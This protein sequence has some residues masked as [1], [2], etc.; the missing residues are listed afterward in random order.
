MAIFLSILFLVSIRSLLLNELPL[1]IAPRVNGVPVSY[2]RTE[3][4]APR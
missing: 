4:T 1:L 2:P 3:A